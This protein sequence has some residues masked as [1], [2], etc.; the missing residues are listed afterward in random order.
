MSN[1]LLQ[2]RGRLFTPDLTQAGIAGVVRALAIELAARQGSEIVQCPLSLTDCFEAEALYL[3]NS[4]IGVVPVVRLG[5]HR[6]DAD[7]AEP[8]LLGSVRQACFNS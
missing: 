8:A 6:F 7:I 3:T 1:L 2:R 5:E 4:L